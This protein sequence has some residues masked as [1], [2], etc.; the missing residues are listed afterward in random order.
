MVEY[1]KPI[2]SLLEKSFTV[3][4]PN[5]RKGH[6]CL[7]KKG[8]HKIAVTEHHAVLNKKIAKKRLGVKLVQGGNK[9]KY[10][11][12]YLMLGLTFI[13]NNTNIKFSIRV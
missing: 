10:S 7:K 5:M 12:P 3:L 13:L 11:L 4:G 9:M 1:L 2:C 8:N 6:Y